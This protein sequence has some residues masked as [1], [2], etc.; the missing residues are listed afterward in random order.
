MHRHGTHPSCAVHR[1]STERGLQSGCRFGYG[2]STCRAADAKPRTSGVKAP[3]AS[4]DAQGMGHAE[5]SPSRWIPRHPTAILITALAVAGSTACSPGDGEGPRY[6]GRVTSASARQVCVG[7]NTSS[8]SETCGWVPAGSLNLPRVGQCVDLF[9]H[10]SDQGRHRTWTA[11]S[12]RL[13]VDDSEC[14]TSS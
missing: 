10:F 11:T 6:T 2:G 8:R 14:R 3:A 1:S 5:A 12:L 4:T 7:P 13:S 9:A